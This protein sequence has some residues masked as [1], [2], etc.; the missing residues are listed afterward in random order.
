VLDSVKCFL[1]ILRDDHVIF[2]FEFVYVVD[3]IDGFLYIKPCLHPSDE[4][5]LIIMDDHVLLY[6]VCENFFEYF[7]VAIHK[8]NLSE[9]LF[10]C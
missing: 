2:V 3:Y 7:Y 9:V 8:G 1:G 10:I 5:Y 4:A 6:S